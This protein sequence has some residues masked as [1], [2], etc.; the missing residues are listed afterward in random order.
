MLERSVVG[1]AVPNDEV[2]ATNTEATNTELR[3]ASFNVLG[4]HSGSQEPCR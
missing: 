3:D 2:E 1:Y 4:W